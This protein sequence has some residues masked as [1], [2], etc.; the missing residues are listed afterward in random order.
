MAI[1]SRLKPGRWLRV[2]RRVPTGTEPAAVLRFLAGGGIVSGK[3]K[4]EL[5]SVGGTYAVCECQL[6]T[7]QPSPQTLVEGSLLPTAPQSRSE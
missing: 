4:E 7:M 2:V 5:V 3:R 1:I 6:T